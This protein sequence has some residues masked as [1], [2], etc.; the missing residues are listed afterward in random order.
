MIDPLLRKTEYEYAD[1]GTGAIES[2][3]YAVA[4]PEE[5][6]YVYEHDDS[7][8]ITSETDELE[9]RTEYDYDNLDRLIKITLPDPDTEDEVDPPT[10]EYDRC[11]CGAVKSVTDA[12]GVETE[13][14]H[15]NRKHVR[16]VTISGGGGST[17]V[18]AN[19]DPAGNMD[20]TTDALNNVTTYV[21]D[22]LNRWTEMHLPDPDTG[23]EIDAPIIYRTYDARQRDLGDRPKRQFDLVQI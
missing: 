9:N 20:S 19:Y 8:N 12:D 10:I 15:D 17:T 2:V 6:E 16:E 4:L 11:V 5:S 3:A 21:F 1:D 23:D 13:Y 14:K 18:M 7:G 22:E